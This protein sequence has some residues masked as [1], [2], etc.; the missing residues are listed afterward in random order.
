MFMI[1]FWNLVYG[2]S[3]NMK[4]CEYENYEKLKILPLETFQVRI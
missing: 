2:N 4:I 3:K 1:E